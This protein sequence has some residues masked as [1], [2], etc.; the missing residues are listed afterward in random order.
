MT[1][2]SLTSSAPTAGLGLL[3]GRARAASRAA[4][5]SQSASLAGRCNR[6]ACLVCCLGNGFTGG[7]RFQGGFAHAFSRQ[8]GTA[9]D[10]CL[11]DIFLC[12]SELLP[13]LARPDSLSLLPQSLNI[14]C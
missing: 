1:A 11:A 14:T 5:A 7:A 8:A 10:F 9:A 6:S 13:R 12:E 3:S 4:A 2:L